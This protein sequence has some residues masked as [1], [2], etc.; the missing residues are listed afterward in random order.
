M[1]I[2]RA[3][4]VAANGILSLVFI[5]EWYSVAY[6]LYYIGIKYHIFFI[7]INILN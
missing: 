3:T 1:V 4:C 5:A 6:I 7:R 2:S